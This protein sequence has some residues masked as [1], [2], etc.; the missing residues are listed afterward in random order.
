MNSVDH[1]ML[2]LWFL[3]SKSPAL[4]LEQGKISNLNPAAH[5][6]YGDSL[7]KG[8]DLKQL[9]PDFSMSIT[10]EQRL[11]TSEGLPVRVELIRE[12]DDGIAMVV[13][14]HSRGTHQDEFARWLTNLHKVSKALSECQTPDEVYRFAVDAAK[15]HLDIDRIGLL[16]IVPDTNEFVGTWG[17]DEDGMTVNESD[18]REPIPSSPWA[19]ETLA[20]KDSVAVWENIPL[21]HYGKEVGLGWNAMAALWDGEEAIGWIA[22]DNLLK[23][24]PMT[25]EHRE[26]IRLYASLLA[27]TII[28]KRAELQLRNINEHLERTVEDRTSSLNDKMDELNHTQQRLIQAEKRAALAKLVVGVAHEINNP[29]AMV[30]SNL[31]VMS[32]YIQDLQVLASD[33][34]LQPQLMDHI[35]ELPEIVNDCATAL[36]RIKLITSDLQGFSVQHVGQQEKTELQALILALPK[37]ASKDV[38]IALQHP[39][40]ADA[41]VS[42]SGNQLQK[43]LQQIVDNSISAIRQAGRKEGQIDISCDQPANDRVRISVRD[44]GCGMTKEVINRAFDPFFTTKQVGQGTGLGLAVASSLINAAGGSIDLTSQPAKGTTVIIELP[45]LIHQKNVSQI[46]K[47]ATGPD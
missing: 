25:A 11:E 24:R 34:L 35:L 2:R 32:Q 46:Q 23:R 45:A 18:Y 43:V 16:L 31:S 28:R 29:L 36:D 19:E 26:V 40:R 33:Q 4:I 17:T 5:Y 12:A 7:T 37:R 42:I 41:T 13:I 1:E 8:C 38:V 47:R 6:F 30:I 39:E 22:C 3:Q 9:I 15:R 14:H 20:R 44:N 27:Q 10:G 21:H